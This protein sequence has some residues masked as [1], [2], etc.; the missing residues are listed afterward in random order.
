VLTVE[1]V[2]PRA[3]MSGMSRAQERRCAG[4]APRRGRGCACPL[5][6]RFFSPPSLRGGGPSLLL[7][8][9]GGPRG[10]GGG[11][12]GGLAAPPRPMAMGALAS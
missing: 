2:S 1:T 10:G 12:P 7:L 8:D 6:A 9:G 4:A 5:I 11:P 3:M